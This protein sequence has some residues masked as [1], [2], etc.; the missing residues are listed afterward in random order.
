MSCSRRPGLPWLGALGT[1]GTQSVVDEEEMT[2]TC[3]CVWRGNLQPREAQ[4]VVCNSCSVLVPGARGRGQPARGL[5]DSS[6]LPKRSLCCFS[7]APYFHA[8]GL[9]TLSTF[10]IPVSQ[11]VLLS[12]ALSHFRG[13][14]VLEGSMD[15]PRVGCHL[16]PSLAF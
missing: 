3:L 7:G 4:R 12:F 2:E 13:A 8:E 1:V 10:Q 5:A 9:P 16:A 6:Q 11:E 15:S 14:G